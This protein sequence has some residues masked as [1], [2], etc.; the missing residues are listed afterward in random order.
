M[1]FSERT[2]DRFTS[3]QLERS[4]LPTNRIDPVR[5][6]V[7]SAIFVVAPWTWVGLF[8]VRAGLF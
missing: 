5:L 8:W 4:S 3:G 7:W 6:S 2:L 1:A